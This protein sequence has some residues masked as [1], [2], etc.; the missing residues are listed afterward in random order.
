VSHWKNAPPVVV[1][2]GSHDYLREREIREAV[3][4]ADVNGRSVEYVVGSDRDE[5]AR[6]LSSTGVFF[7][8]EALV[9]VDDPEDVDAD[10][11]LRHHERADNSTVLLLHQKGAIKATSNL[12]RVVKGL[13]DRFVAK[14]EKPKPWEEVDHAAQFCVNEAKKFGKRLDEPL[15]R[16]IVKNAGSDLGV[17]SFEVRKL[18]FLLDARGESHVEAAHVKS[19]I[20]SFSELGPKPVVDAIEKKDLAAASRALANMRRT[21]AGNPSGATLLACAWIGRSATTWLY[22]AS[23]H[24]EGYNLGELSARTG[25]HEF[26]LKKTHLP[27]VRRWGKGRLISL[28][29]SISRV[30]RS[31]RSGHLHPW[32]ELECAVFQCI[33][34]DAPR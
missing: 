32:V 8:E 25:M 31:V 1:L 34:E 15:A 28:V 14:F 27:V 10:M 6:I 33:E 11:V 5:I 23:L 19:T 12:G 26:L 16:A 3:T 20:A 2:S 7:K 18:S 24:E 17:L 22:V 4:V 30:E 29:K 21:H 9:V 13:P